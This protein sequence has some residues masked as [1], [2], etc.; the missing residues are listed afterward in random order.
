MSSPKEIITDI[1]YDFS[2][3][4]G[5]A[6]LVVDIHGNEISPQFN[7][8]P[9]CEQIRSYENLK[10]ICQKCDMCGGIESLR[11]NKTNFYRCHAGLVD[12]SI[13]LIIKGT[14][15]GFVQCGQARVNNHFDFPEIIQINSNEIISSQLQDMYLSIPMLKSSKIL[16][17]AEILQ[18]II[19]SSLTREITLPELNGSLNEKPAIV[20]QEIVIDKATRDKE[21]MRRAMQYI[22]DH[23]AEN[24]SLDEVA[25][26]I[27]LSSYY[28]SRLFKQETGVGFN[29]FKVQ[30]RMEKARELLS[31]TNWSIDKVAGKVGYSQTPYFIKQ[32]SKT[33][34]CHPVEAYE[35]R[36]IV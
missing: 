27:H 35:N 17:S 4:T 12:F 29:T 15:M 3:A 20:H 18:K 10:N 34:D 25:S 28:F 26:S 9:F 14:L 31:L 30:R 11:Q 21:R 7:F 5:L 2:E 32:F 16:S 22:D 6:V 24:L 33:F 13:P 19:G 1:A 36:I 23:L 8:T